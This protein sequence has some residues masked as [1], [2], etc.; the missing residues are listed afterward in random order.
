MVNAD[1][2]WE[3]KQAPRKRLQ[4]WALDHL[5]PFSSSSF[6]YRNVIN[7]HNFHTKNVRIVQTPDFKNDDYVDWSNRTAFSDK[8]ESKRLDAYANRHL[9]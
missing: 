5:N 7:K 1:C 9:N 4:Q 2:A 6:F 3:K 8:L